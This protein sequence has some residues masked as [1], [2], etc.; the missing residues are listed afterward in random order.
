MCLVRD[1]LI[2][3]YLICQLYVLMSMQRSYCFHTVKINA[4]DSYKRLVLS[5]SEDV[6]GNR[7]KPCKGVMH[8]FM[9]TLSKSKKTSQLRFMYRNFKM[10]DTKSCETKIFFK[11]FHGRVFSRNDQYLETYSTIFSTAAIFLLYM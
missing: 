2:Y 8:D 1:S 9:Q 7:Q 5:K 10:K 3:K 6:E 4:N 11:V